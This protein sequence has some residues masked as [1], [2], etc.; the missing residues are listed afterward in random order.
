MRALLIGSRAAH[1][2][3]IDLGRAPGDADYFAD[4]DYPERIAEIFGMKADVFWDTAFDAWLPD[5]YRCRTATPDELYTI[6]LSHAAW[7]LPPQGNWEKHMH[8]AMTL[9]A[10]GARVDEDLYQLLYGVWQ[11][12]HGAKRVNLQM[13]SDTFFADAVDRAYD[14]DSLHRSVAYSPGKPIYERVLKPGATVDMDMDAVWAMPFEQQIRL[15]REEIYVTALE[16]IIIPSSYKRSPGWAYSWALRRTV[17]SLT[18]G[19]SSRFIAENYDIFRTADIDY[20]RH[21]RANAHH[22]ITV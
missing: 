21:H 7:E 5:D 4:N 1:K 15:F 11:R 22:L 9:K 8:D 10:A 13:E 19:R 3:G 14:H 6:K 18:K 17:T 16:R 2:N 20:V 12:Q